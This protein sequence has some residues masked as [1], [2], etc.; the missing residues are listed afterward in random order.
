V[1]EYAQVPYQVDSSSQ[2]CNVLTGNIAEAIYRYNTYTSIRFV[3]RSDQADF[4]NIQRSDGNCNS[5]LGRIGGQQTI[6]LDG[7]G[8]CSPAGTL[9]EMAHTLGLFHTQSRQDR[10]TYINVNWTN[11]N[12]AFHSQYNKYSDGQDLFDYDYASV[13][14]S[15]PLVPRVPRSTPWLTSSRCLNLCTAPRAPLVARQ[16]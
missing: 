1:F 10:D 8:Y 6:N 13:M 14:P 16:A 3:P 4:V 15:K 9:H 5:N 2:A 7:R 11:I 12:T